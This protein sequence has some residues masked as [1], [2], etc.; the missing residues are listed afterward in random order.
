M[1]LFDCSM[2][3]VGLIDVGYILLK[4]VIENCDWLQEV[5]E[6]IV[7]FDVGSNVVIVVCI[8]GFVI[9]WLMLCFDV[10]YCDYFDIV[11][12][13]Q[14]VLQEVLIFG[15]GI[16][17]VMC[18]G[19]GVWCDGEVYLFFNEVIELVCVFMFVEKISVDGGSFVLVFL[20]YVEFFDWCWVFWLQY[21]LCIDQIVKGL[22][23]GLKFFNYVQVIQVVFF[24]YGVMFGWCFI[25]G[26]QIVNGLFVFVGLLLFYFGDV[27]YVVFFYKSCN[28]EIVV[29]VVEWVKDVVVWEG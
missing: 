14:M 20:I 6:E 27:Y 10:F 8:M 9:Y 12:N 17:I 23:K 3:F 22:V 19:D 24:G 16:D 2:W 11:V 18:Y 29:M 28:V 25:I 4:V 5:L 21:F 7:V 26:D 15:F 1:L 13:V